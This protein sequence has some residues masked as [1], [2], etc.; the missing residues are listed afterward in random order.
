M[1]RPSRATSRPASRLLPALA[2]LALLAASAPAQTWVPLESPSAPGTPAEVTFLP[3]ESGPELAT[4]EIKL[5]GFWQQD[6]VGDDGNTYQRLTIPGLAG[7]DQVGAPELPAARFALAVPS[8]ATVVSLGAVQVLK[9]ATFSGLRIYPT[10]LPGED[11]EPSEDP[12]PGDTKGYEDKFALDPSIYALT[13]HWP[14]QVA[15]PSFPVESLLGPIKGA[16]VSVSPLSWNPVTAEL[17]AKTWFKLQLSFSGGGSGPV[18]LNKP[19]VQAAAAAFINWPALGGHFKADQVDYK[20]RLLILASGQYWDEL[21]DFIALKQAMGFQ[22]ELRAKS[23]TVDGVRDIIAD[24]YAEGHPEMDHYCLLVGDASSIPL[25]MV[26]VGGESVQTDDL[27]GAVGHDSLAKDIHVGRLSVDNELDLTR[28]LKKIMEYQTAPVPGG[29]YE[30]AL[31]VAHMEGWPGKYMGAHEAVRTAGYSNPPTFLTRYGPF[32]L[33]DGPTAGDIDAGVGLVAY[34]GHGSTNAMTEWNLGG[35]SFNKADVLSLDNTVLPVFWSFACTNANIAFDGSSQDDCLAETW[36]EADGAGAVAAYAATRTTATKVNHM[37]DWLAF[38]VLYNYG[39]STHGQ[40]LDV[41]ELMLWAFF[42]GSYNPWAY[43]LLGDPTMTV[44]TE[45]AQDMLTNLPSAAPLGALAGQKLKVQVNFDNGLPAGGA[46][47]SAHK[48]AFLGGQPD[49]LL[50]AKWLAGDGSVLLELPAALTPGDINVVA[51]TAD[52]SVKLHTIKVDMDPA[53][54]GLG[55]ALPPVGG[56][57]PELVGLGSLQGGSPMSLLVAGAAP[58]R[59]AW[60]MLGLAVDPLPFKGGLLIPCIVPPGQVLPLA[61]DVQGNIALEAKWPDGVPSGVS[62][63]TQVWVQ[64]AAGPKGFTASNALE[65][66][67]P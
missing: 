25:G 41:A 44:R 42:P 51:R 30:K 1:N 62:I 58:A 59:P 14:D 50:A 18:T 67:T 39:I 35:T 29:H 8:K 32:E 55:S 34:R 46:L 65:G 64:D 6:V 52:G 53:W 33:S 60:L 15:A 36:M 24:W 3:A 5:H 38:Q 45:Q 61:T 63:Y 57:A 37:H 43:L 31:L 23:N 21:Q 2:A 66:R 7:I 47:L 16:A 22:T 27:Y 13:K 9:Q 56:Q 28:Q 40:A 10:P 20:A 48:A 54:T 49:E 26:S 11:E 4:V 12:G 19:K 17:L